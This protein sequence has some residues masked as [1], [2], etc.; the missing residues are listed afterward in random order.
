MVKSYFEYLNEIT[1]DE[2]YEG[3]L[4]YGLFSNKLPPVFTSE[5]FFQYCIFSIAPP[6]SGKERDYVTFE[7][8]RNY[9]VPRSLGIPNPMA[10]EKLC[11]VLRDNW[12]LIQSHFQKVT[13]GQTYKVSRIHIRK[14]RNKPSLFEMTY[15]N[16][17]NDGFPDPDLLIGSRYVVR[18]DISTCFPSIYTHSI[19]WALA[20]KE[21]AKSDR[22]AGL[23]AVR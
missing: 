16:W 12:K 4:A 14:M 8:M 1:E 2:I 23:C 20:G 19:C 22:K 10:Y 7:I 5:S 15:S 17:K 11:A 3:L 13:L 21:I 9:N 6:F 18:A